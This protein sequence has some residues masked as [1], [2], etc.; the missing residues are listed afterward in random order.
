[1]SGMAVYNDVAFFDNSPP[2]GHVGILVAFIFLVDAQTQVFLPS[3]IWTVGEGG[4]QEQ[5]IERVRRYARI[6][7]GVEAGNP[8]KVLV[9]DW[10]QE[11]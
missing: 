6:L 1:M 8:V 3:P 4:V 9:Q 5:H 11:K 2:E 7:F 10:S